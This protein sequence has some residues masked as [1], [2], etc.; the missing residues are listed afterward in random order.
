MHEE[1]GC[2]ESQRILEVLQATQA[3]TDRWRSLG[4]TLLRGMLA[5]SPD[6]E[7]KAEYR[8]VVVKLEGSAAT[9][10]T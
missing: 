8:M 7:Q 5:W 1:Q 6:R 2:W 3:C 9:A 10:K 4:L